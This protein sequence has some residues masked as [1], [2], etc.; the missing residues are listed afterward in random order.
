M[1]LLADEGSLYLHCA[2]R[3]ATPS[4][5]VRRDLRQPRTSGTR[6]SGG[7]PMPITIRS[8]VG[9]IHDVIL[10]YGKTDRVVWNEQHIRVRARS[11]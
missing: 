9:R 7:A 10:Y 4:G 5:G 1:S 11:T 8:V 3:S 2:P 6:S